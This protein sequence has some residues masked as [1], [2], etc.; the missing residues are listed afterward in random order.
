MKLLFLL[1][2]LLLPSEKNHDIQV[3][4]FKVYSVPNGLM[5]DIHFESEDILAELNIDYTQISTEVIS[6]YLHQNLKFKLENKM[7][8]F[9]IKDLEVDGKHLLITSEFLTYNASFK[10]I[11]IQNT[12]LLSLEGQSNII[13]VRIEDQERDFLMNTARMHINIDL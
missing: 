8:D 9:R 13:E 3:A 2:T 7:I 1:L 5:L 4:I 12:C 10:K 6:Q 11:E